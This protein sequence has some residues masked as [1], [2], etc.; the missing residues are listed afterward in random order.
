MPL[1]LAERQ[2]GRLPQ[3]RED[4]RVGKARRIALAVID[5]P[6]NMQGELSAHVIIVSELNRKKIACTIKCVTHDN[7]SVGIIDTPDADRWDHFAPPFFE[8]L[9]GLY[10]SAVR[11]AQTVEAATGWRIK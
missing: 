2:L 9:P 5:I 4:S 10:P 3:K 11:F 7:Q 6:N 1:S 8:G